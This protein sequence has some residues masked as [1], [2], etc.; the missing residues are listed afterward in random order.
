MM[1]NDATSLSNKVLAQ[2]KLKELGV[3]KASLSQHGLVL[4]IQ[5]P[6][7]DFDQTVAKREAIVNQ[8]KAIGYRFIALDLDDRNV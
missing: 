4:R 2:Q 8:M 6:A 3:E 1:N 5:V 7:A